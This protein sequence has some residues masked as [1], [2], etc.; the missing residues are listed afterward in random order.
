MKKCIL[1]PLLLLLLL[2]GCQASPAEATP[3]AATI[4]AQAALPL[5]TEPPVVLAADTALPFVRLSEAVPQALQHPVLAE[6]NSLTGPALYDHKEIWLRAGTA[7]KL[8]AV[9]AELE[10]LGYALVVWDGYQNAEARQAL[11]ALHPQLNW[12][13]AGVRGSA[14]DVGLADLATGAPVPLPSAYAD[15]TEAAIRGYQGC[16]AAA[17]ENARLLE[18]VMLRHGFEGDPDRWWRFWDTDL[19]PL[20][21]SFDPAAPSRWASAEELPLLEAPAEVPQVL[22][23]VPAGE[24][25]TLLA[26]YQGHAL[27]QWGDLRGYVPAEKI[28]PLNPELWTTN[29]DDDLYLFRWPSAGDEI[30]A[31]PQAGETFTFVAWNFK[32]A[33]VEFNGKTGFVRAHQV[34]PA[35]E[36]ALTQALTAV[37]V[38]DTYTYEAMMEDLRWFSLRY[39]KTAQL[40]IIGQ[41]EMGRDIP[42]LRIGDPDAAHHVL[43]QA[44]I[45]GREHMT[46]WLAMALADYWLDHNVAAYG[47]VCYHIIPMSNPDGVTISQ[48]ATLNEEQ[49]KIFGYDRGYSTTSPYITTYAREWKANAL[50]VDLNQNFDANWEKAARRT[51]PSAMRYRGES[52][53]CAKESQAL[54][55]YTLRY[56]FGVTISYHSEGSILYYNYGTRQP[57]NDLSA[58]LAHHV[59]AFT[60]YDLKETNSCGGYKDWA[61]D[62]LGIPSLTVETGCYKSPLALEEVYNIFFRNQVMLPEL[63]RWLASP[64]TP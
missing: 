24:A 27:V 3:A 36:T 53:F 17:L 42:V 47:D 20:E 8:A 10:E 56:D 39:S 25:L 32:F 54:R 26:F 34:K 6:E 30:L 38:T 21:D 51:I 35:D 43:I 31:E 44:A 4:P 50:G 40:E 18:D 52:V 7:Q 2:A 37:E 61:M 29:I 41:S 64:E 15:T 33:Q 22:A 57:V 5:P 12:D 58:A 49:T 23:I 19:Y 48:T 28:T 63:A 55:D 1:L 13:F 9:S 11:C 46:A 16:S 59:N 60:G 62:A 14:V 45:H